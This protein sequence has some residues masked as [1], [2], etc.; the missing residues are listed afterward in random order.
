MPKNAKPFKENLS[1]IYNELHLAKRWGKASIILTVHRSTYSQDKTK[2]A[3]HKKLGSLD[4]DVVEVPINNV[5]GNF[6]DYM[7]QYKN[8]EKTVFFISNIGWGGGDD[9]NDGYRV[10]NLFRE[11]FIEQGLRVIF[12]LTLSEAAKLPSYAPDFW[13]FRHH[14]LEFGSPRA[15]NQKR[16]PVRLLLWHVENPFTSNIDIKGKISNLTKILTDINDQTESVSLRIDLLYEL[17]FLYWL[18]GDHLKAEK[19]LMD[20]IDLAKP[21]GITDLLVR[22]WN[23]L[24]ILRYEREDYHGAMNLLEST[25][26]ENPRDCLLFLNQA[27]VMFATKKRY[28]AFIKGKKATSIC[29]Q[30]PWIW[31]SLGFLYYFAGKTD[32]A[33]A[34]FQTAIDLSSKIGYFHE[35]LAVC[36][37]SMGLSDKAHAQLAQAQKN[38]DTRDMFLGVLHDCIKGDTE[39]ASLLINAEVNAGKITKFEIERDPILYALIEPEKLN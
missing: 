30:N 1:I 6:I 15:Y 23:G 4:Y 18:L 9:E 21:Y 35:S 20:G 16:P 7:I 2:N 12:F 27:I 5:E 8:V 37:L 14:V 25:I 38:S 29:T 13:A 39:S 22:L 11:T 19:N 34:C 10:L 17:G 3:L 33:V 26:E 36:Y 31:N 24:A 28:Q 32:E